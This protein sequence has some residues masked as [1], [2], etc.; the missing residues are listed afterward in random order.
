MLTRRAAKEEV[1]LEPSLF[2]ILTILF[3]ATFIRS[4]FGFGE[5]LVAIPLLAFVIPVHVSAPVTGLMSITISVIV[6]IQDW[7]YI[8][9]DSLGRLTVST[10]I[11]VPIGLVLLTTI[12]EQFLK[13]ILALVIVAF[14]TYSLL[15]RTKRSLV[16]DRLAWL[17][18]LSSGILAGAYS[19]GGPP[20]AI[21][22]AIRGWSPQHF[23]ATLQGYFLPV[24]IVVMAGYWLTGLLTPAVT[25]YYLMALPL[26]ILGTFLGRLANLR[27]KGQSFLR[28]VY[29]GLLIIGFMLLRQS[30]T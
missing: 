17:F 16:D 1:H 20:I 10:L 29:F 5:A 23:R 27:M 30:L 15:S 11:G 3:I 28:Y 12:N 9:F 19:M 4:A 13:A 7:R 8:Q 18:G 24:S 26:V 14:S 22:G 2:L 6:I 21:Y 25:N